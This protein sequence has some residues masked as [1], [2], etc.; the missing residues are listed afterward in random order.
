M[1]ELNK[2][3]NTIVLQ[4]GFEHK[5]I[6]ADDD[7]LRNIFVNL[8]SNAIKFSPGTTRVWLQVYD[9]GENLRVEIKDKGIGIRKEDLMKIFEPFERGKN[10]KGIQG[11]GLG[12]SIAKKAV[13]LIGGTIDVSSTPGKGSIF[14]V[15][16]PAT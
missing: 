9:L 12:L 1:E 10:T 2:G 8:I 7:L 16:I 15:T 5:Y 14:T 13:D 11:T 4:F 3:S 6:D